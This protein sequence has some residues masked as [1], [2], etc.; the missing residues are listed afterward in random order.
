VRPSSSRSPPDRTLDAG[1]GTGTSAP[2]CGRG[3]NP[4]GELGRQ[5][6]AAVRDAHATALAPREIVDVRGSG[7][8]APNRAAGRPPGAA[9]APVGEVLP[10]RLDPTQAVL[11][12]TAR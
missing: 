1:H 11:V 9:H 8:I 4:H 5:L 7:L 2:P 12:H 3:S 6:D 10:H